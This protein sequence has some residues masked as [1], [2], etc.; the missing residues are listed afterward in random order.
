VVAD[1][2]TMQ[3]DLMAP[4]Y[5]GAGVHR[6]YPLVDDLDREAT[7]RAVDLA[8]DVGL[9]GVWAPDHFMLGPKRQEYEVWT[10]LAAVAERTDDLDLGPLVGSITYRNPAL[11]AKMATT[12][13][14]LSGGRVRLG[15]GAGW[16]EEEHAAYGYDFPDVNTRIEMLDESLR[17]VKAMFTEEE[18]SFHGDHYQIEDAYNRPGP[19]QDPH[20]PVVV[21]GAGPRML[22]LVARHADEWNVEISARARGK[23]IDFKVRKF[24]EY[25]EAEGR[26]PDDVER[27]WLAHVLVC[28]DEAELAEYV[29]R[30]FPLPWGEESD[31]DETLDDATEA[32]EKGSML[33][34]T[35]SQVAEQIERIESLGFEKLQLM[36]L[37]FPETRGMEL[38]ADEVLPEFQS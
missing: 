18:P 2:E 26:D 10:F 27:S 33:I 32:R 11:L 30:I 24:D 17:V 13:D 20:P 3:F 29:D 8:A 16:H 4:V 5:A 38:F 37:D 12:V 35:P 21:G 15:L 14:N 7:M 31:M 9:G 28:E 25:L 19:V 34:G 23:P 6:D 22:R 36:F 1:R